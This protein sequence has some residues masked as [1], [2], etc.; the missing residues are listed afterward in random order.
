MKPRLLLLALVC[1]FRAHSNA[2]A[3]PRPSTI[4]I[5][6]DDMGWGDP[7]CYGNSRIQTPNL[8]RLAKQGTLFEQFYVCGSVCSPSRAAFMTGQFPAR[9][10]VHS[11]IG[12]PDANK[13]KTITD[14]LDPKVPTVTL[15]LKQAGY[16][17]AHFG[18]WHLGIGAKAPK[19]DAYGIDAGRRTWF[20]PGDK[21]PT[22]ADRALRTQD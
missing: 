1:I 7:N 3:A 17:T 21:R 13:A 11:A 4:F 18:K 2:A 9:L 15:L 16:A 19:P 14:W 5:L 12:A 20:W 22:K 8:D 6:A 10:A